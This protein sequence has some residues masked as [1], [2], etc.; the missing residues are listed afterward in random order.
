MWRMACRWDAAPWTLRPAPAPVASRSPTSLT[1]SGGNP[2]ST[3]PTLT[4]TFHP[5]VRPETPPQPVT[6]K[7]T[8]PSTSP[9]HTHVLTDSMQASL[10]VYY[11]WRWFANCAMVFRFSP[12]WNTLCS[13]ES[14]PFTVLLSF[15]W[16]FW[17]RVCICQWDF[18]RQKKITCVCNSHLK[19]YCLCFADETSK[20]FRSKSAAAE[21]EV[22]LMC[23]MDPLFFIRSVL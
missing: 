8:P 23:W 20:I 9:L 12:S 16:L 1:A 14:S 22:S 10:P 17:S 13:L 11:F 3:A 4:L 15:M 21:P 18:F 6:C 5:R 19:F 7:F 2:S